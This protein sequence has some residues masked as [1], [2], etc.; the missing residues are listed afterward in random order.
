MYSMMEGGMERVHLLV[1][2]LRRTRLLSTNVLVSTAA[3]STRLR[4]EKRDEG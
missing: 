1:L 3:D 2:C 4:G